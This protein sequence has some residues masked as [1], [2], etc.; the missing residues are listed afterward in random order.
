MKHLY[1]QHR[2]P[3]L[4]STDPARLDLDVIHGY[5]TRSYWSPGIPRELVERGIAN[6]LNF[7]LYCSRA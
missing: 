6:S 7:G 2:D 5:L 4:I 3:Y 1:E